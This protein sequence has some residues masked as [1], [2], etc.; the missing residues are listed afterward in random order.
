MSDQFDF[1]LETN[2]ARVNQ[3]TRYM[4]KNG[5]DDLPPIYQYKTYYFS[6]VAKSEN[7]SFEVNAHLQVFA[8]VPSFLYS[9]FFSPSRKYMLYSANVLKDF[10]GRMAYFEWDVVPLFIKMEDIPTR[11][12]VKMMF[13]VIPFLQ[14]KMRGWGDLSPV[15]NEPVVGRVAGYKSG[16]EKDWESMKRG[17]KQREKMA[18]RIG[19]GNTGIDNNCYAYY[20]ENC[21]IKP[22]MVD[23]Q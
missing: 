11:D 6:D 23:T 4:T 2:A 21:E 17:T 20:D 14:E 3:F 15:G 7:V 18:M 8:N 19:F 9:R 10:K 22:I 16:Q 13:T 5:Y 12:K 1:P